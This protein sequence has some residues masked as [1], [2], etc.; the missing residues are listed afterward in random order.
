[1]II[2]RNLWRR[3]TR[4]LLTWVGITIGITAI[5]TLTAIAEGFL[6]NY[7]QAMANSD[8]DLALQ[9]KQEAGASIDMAEAMISDR[10]GAELKA[11]P[12]VRA[13]TSMLYTVVPMPGVPYFVLFGHE[14]DGFAI[15]RFKLTAGQRLGAAERVAGRPIMLGK[16]AADSLHK[17]VGDTVTIYSRTYRVVGIYETGSVMEDG[18]A[19]VSVD[20]VQR[21]TN[22][23]SAVHS[24]W[25]QLER[26]ERLQDRYPELQVVR[27]G[28]TRSTAVW[29]ELVR[30]FTWAVALIAALVGGVGM[31]NA[32]LMSIFERTREIGVLRA[33]GW[34]GRQVM[35]MIL[36]ESLVLS[37]AGA[38]CGT[39]LSVALISLLGRVPALAGLTRGSLSPSLLGQAL[40]TALV[41]GTVGGLYPA[42]RASRLAPVEALRYEGAALGTRP[43]LVWG[44]LAFRNVLRQR[45]R[46]ALTCLGVGIGALAVVAMSALGEGMMSEFG[47]M[48]GTAELTIVQGNISDMSLSSISERVGRQIEALPE[49]EYA[50]GGTLAFVSM[51]GLPMFIIGGYPAYSPHLNRYHL[52]NGDVPK[53]PGQIMLGWKAAESLRKDIGDTFAALGS[54]FRVTGI[55]ETGS[56]YED[57]GGVTTLRELQTR[58][59]KPRQVMF[60]EI[61]LVHPEQ[62]TAVQAQ[63]ASQFPDLSISRSAE[64]AENLPD[65]RM[66]QNFTNALAAMTFLI[67]SVLVMNTMVMSVRERTRELG[68]LRALGWGRGQILR[69][70]V[71]ESLMLTLF[72]GALGIAAAWLLMRGL[73]LVPALGSILRATHFTPEMAGRVAV[74][75]AGL[76]IVGGIY[77]AWRAMQLLPVEALRYE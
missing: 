3:R 54:Q 36:G 58:M 28:D 5:I 21:L 11:N 69:L 53:S 18:G 68:V 17:A 63:L 72:S 6:S 70:I 16:I 1:M 39:L 46:S 29:L 44:G 43:G 64:F 66:T 75:C 32:T 77:P 40:T 23:P 55:Y 67:G 24:F 62:A 20:E 10:Y 7:A 15:S 8:G 41:L 38:V 45:T 2:L 26:P 22:K 47:R 42:W 12:E 27:S 14:P 25:I 31:M 73:A 37:I 50:A 76:G 51:P 57:S 19:V 60:Y 71:H 9:A 35:S 56:E 34:R 65:M 4:T 48:L 61:K 74:L 13:V 49:V 59:G 52:R 30:P 33:L